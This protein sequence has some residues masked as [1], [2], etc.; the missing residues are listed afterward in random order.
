MSI[1]VATDY[2][3]QRDDHDNNNDYVADDVVIKETNIWTANRAPKLMAFGSQINDK[4]IH[5]KN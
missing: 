5:Q 2:C 3:L 1:L 4:K